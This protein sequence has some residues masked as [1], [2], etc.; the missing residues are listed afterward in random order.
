MKGKFVLLSLVLAAAVSAQCLAQE[1]VGFEDLYKAGQAHQEAG[2]YAEARAEYEKALA[3]DGITPDQTGRVLVKIGDAFLK[4]K[5]VRDGVA[6][7]KKALAMKEISNPTRIEANLL[8]G[9]AYLAYPWVLDQSRDAF[10]E[11]LNLP[12]ATPEQKTAARKGLIEAQIGLRQFGKAREIMLAL[13]D[14]PNL[15]PAE[16]TSNQISIGTTCLLEGMYVE[17]RTELG[18][19]LEMKGLSDAQKVDIQLKIALSYYEAGDHER[20]Q[21]ELEKILNMPRADAPPFRSDGFGNSVAS[22]MRAA[23]MRLLKMS[24]TDER[25][26]TIAAIFIGSSMTIRGYMPLSVENMASSAP[27]GQPRIIAG[28]YVRGGTKIDAFWNNGETRDTARGALSAAP[29]DVV[30]IETFDNMTPE[31]LMKYGKLFADFARS[32]NIAPVLYESHPRFAQP[33]PEAALKYHNSV[34]KV[35]KA[36][37]APVAPVLLA[38][39]KYLEAVPTAKREEFYDDWV[40]PS[41]KGRYM[42]AYCI[43]ATVTG[44]SPV[45]LPHTGGITDEEAKAMQEAAWNAVRETNPNLKPWKPVEANPPEPPI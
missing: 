1:T 32:R 13:A 9:Q 45:G 22:P 35:G 29:W 30:V 2:R 38:E 7:L 20:A 15:T 19:A 31:D 40:H 4:E 43:Y 39:M 18:K 16:K 5:K 12:E 27:E 8:F 41:Q 3:V 25:K 36:L 6:A 42:A 23:K 44:Y 11:V 21:P 24:E 10:I 34:V 14:D 26:N 37:N 33:Y 28:M 17:A